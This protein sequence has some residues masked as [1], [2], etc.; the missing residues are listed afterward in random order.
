M[1][2]EIYW[3][4]VGPFPRVAIMARPR[5]GD[6]LEDEI[7]HWK[8]AGVEVV[9][10]LLERDEIQDL[11]LE[12]EAIRCENSGIQFLS[13]PIPDRAVPDDIAHALRFASDLAGRDKAIAIHCRAG[14]G[15]S[16]VMAAA[17]LISAG[18]D[19]AAALSAIQQARGLPV[20]DTEAQRDW[21]L[22]LE[23]L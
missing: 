22:K 15:R 3:I 20:P 7:A 9:V 11:G 8:R 12:E 16:S 1:A 13:F 21:V 17:V 10:S 5:A 23:R 19:A 14:I 18:I 6:W 4:D 2:S